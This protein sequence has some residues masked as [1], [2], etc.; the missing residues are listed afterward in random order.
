[1][2]ESNIKQDFLLPLELFFIDESLANIFFSF[3]ECW[4]K[5]RT[6]TVVNCSKNL[7]WLNYNIPVCNPPEF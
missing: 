3:S 6:K 7:K 4:R 1:M 2:I 5:R